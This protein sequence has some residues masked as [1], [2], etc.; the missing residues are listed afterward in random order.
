MEWYKKTIDKKIQDGVMSTRVGQPQQTDPNQTTP[1]QT[2]P[3]QTTPNQTTPGQSDPTGSET[4]SLYTENFAPF[5]S[6]SNNYVGTN[7]TLPDIPLRD[8]ITHKNT[9]IEFVNGVA[10]LTSDLGEFARYD[11]KNQN[12]LIGLFQN[13]YPNATDKQIKD[14]VEGNM[15]KSKKIYEDDLTSGASN[16]IKLYRKGQTIGGR[17]VKDYL[18]AYGDDDFVINS[19]NREYSKDGFTFSYVDYSPYP[20]PSNNFSDNDTLSVTHKNYPGKT[21]Y[22]RFDTASEKKD[23]ANT[24]HLMR[25]MNALA[26]KNLDAAYEYAQ[27]NGVINTVGV[28]DANARGMDKYA[29]PGT[30]IENPV[31][32]TGR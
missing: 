25:I 26:N 13:L 27:K 11:K 31:I 21:F 14:F 29:K 9:K 4:F 30:Y 5:N 19:L 2:T 7:A 23:L 17:K 15:K 3:N 20:Q 32:Y 12:K 24:Q 18:L 16:V 6:G 28:V 10:I 8:G 22:I 1:G